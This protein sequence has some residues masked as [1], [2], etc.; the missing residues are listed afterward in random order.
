[1]LSFRLNKLSPATNKVLPNNA[2][3]KP[4]P[5]VLKHRLRNHGHKSD[6]FDL[7]QKHRLSAHR[8]AGDAGRRH[9][10]FYNIIEM[11]RRP[12]NKTK[13]CSLETKERRGEGLRGLEETALSLSRCRSAEDSTQN[14][15]FQSASHS[16]LLAMQTINR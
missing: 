8:L 13:L 3:P 9:H 11:E 10:K 4:I 6:S 14:I 7:R 2:A 1:V 5:I 15:A 16:L 12:K